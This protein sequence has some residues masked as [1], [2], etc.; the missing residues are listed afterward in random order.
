MK[1]NLKRVVASITAIVSLAVSAVSINASASGT[2]THSTN[3]STAAYSFDV[4]GNNTSSTNNGS[5]Y[6]QSSGLYISIV[7]SGYYSVT[8]NGASNSSA[9]VYFYKFNSNNTVSSTPYASFNIPQSVS[10]MPTLYGSIYL[11]SGKYLVKFVSNSYSSYSSGYFAIN[12][13]AYST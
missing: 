3:G 1:K 6:G 4:D 7:N 11:A 10:G 13:V 12:G 2:V 9:T 5:H 8:F